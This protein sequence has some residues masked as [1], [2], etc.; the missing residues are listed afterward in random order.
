M[1][2]D[3]YTPNCAVQGDMGW[4]LPGKLQRTA[5]TWQWC[6]LMTMDTNRINK[7]VFTWTWNRVSIRNKNWVY[8]VSNFY[9]ELRMDHMMDIDTCNQNSVNVMEIVLSEYYEADWLNRLNIVEHRSGNIGR[10]KLRTYNQFKKNLKPEVYLQTVINKRHRST[11]AKF[12]Y[13]VAP[14]RLETG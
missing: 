10:N 14:I 2:V 8:R 9:R 5:F 13:G 3:K 1:G 12:R 6:H 4:P 7:Q 11:L